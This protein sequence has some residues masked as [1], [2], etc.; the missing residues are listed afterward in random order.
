LFELWDPVSQSELFYGV[1][2]TQAARIEPWTPEGEIYATHAFATLAMLSG[3]NSF[4][5]QYVGNMPTAKQFG[6][7]PLYALRR[8]PGTQMSRE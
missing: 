2:M 3:R 5:C 7:M 6:N 4:E 1:G 8:R